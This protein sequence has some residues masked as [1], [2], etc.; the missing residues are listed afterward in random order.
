[1]YCSMNPFLVIDESDMKVI[2]MS[3]PELNKCCPAYMFPHMVARRWLLGDAE[4]YGRKFK[5]VNHTSVLGIAHIF[6]FGL[7][8]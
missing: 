4:K 7:F 2:Y 1:M 6:C 3:G 8:A 5:E